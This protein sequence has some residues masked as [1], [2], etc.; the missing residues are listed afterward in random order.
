MMTK[1]KV[2]KDFTLNGYPPFKK[3]EGKLIKE[4]F[5]KRLIDEKKI[6]IYD[7]E[8]ERKLEEEA[9]KKEQEQ[10]KASDKKTS[11]NNN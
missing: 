6:E 2:L 3:G 1:I 7:E 9:K 4:G 5:V 10:K 11:K 8:K